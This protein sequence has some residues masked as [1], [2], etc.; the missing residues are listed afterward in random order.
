[1][2]AIKQGTLRSTYKGVVERKLDEDNVQKKHDGIVMDDRVDHTAPQITTRPFNTEGILH[3]LKSGFLTM[4]PQDRL[5]Y[6]KRLH[7]SK[8]QVNVPMLF[9]HSEEQAAR[10][11]ALKPFDCDPKLGGGFIQTKL[12]RVKVSR[13]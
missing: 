7:D 2:S 11:K 9:G 3:L 5:I 13:E 10:L 1:M 6:A 4:P 8:E 12:V